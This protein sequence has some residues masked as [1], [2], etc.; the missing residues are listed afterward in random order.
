MLLTFVEVPGV[1]V[2]FTSRTLQVFDHVECYVTQWDQDSV[3]LEMYNPTSYSTVVTLLA[4]ERTNTRSV[5]HNYFGN[6]KMVPLS[7]GERI[8]IELQK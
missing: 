4:D 5:T 8:Q 1:Y 6:M 7:A 2:D 3:H